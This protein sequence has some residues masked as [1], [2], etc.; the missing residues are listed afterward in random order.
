M[1]PGERGFDV[2]ETAAGGTAKPQQAGS[3]VNAGGTDFQA[4]SIC[5]GRDGK[6]SGNEAGEVAGDVE[7][8]LGR[9]VI[10]RR[11]DWAAR[12]RRIGH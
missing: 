1:K 2:D 12:D 4:G 5:F 3:A 11:I 8:G 10:A 9:D 7:R 6:R